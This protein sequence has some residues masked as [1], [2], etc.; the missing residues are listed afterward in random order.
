MVFPR[1]PKTICRVLMN[2][3]PSLF[4]A[5]VLRSKHEYFS[6]RKARQF[7]AC[8]EECFGESLEGFPTQRATL[9][10]EDQL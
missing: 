10:E 7:L 3:G 2:V 5:S 6:E 1:G 9:E 4:V 8:S